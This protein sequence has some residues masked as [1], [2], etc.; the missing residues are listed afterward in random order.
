MFMLGLTVVLLPVAVRNS[1]VGGG[2][3]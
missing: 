1:V 2:F 3:I